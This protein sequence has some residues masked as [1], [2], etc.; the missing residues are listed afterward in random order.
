[1]STQNEFSLAPFLIDSGEN[2]RTIGRP[3]VNQFI[4]DQFINELI[5][6]LINELIN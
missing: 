2:K 5:N 1:M 3:K 4:M 6:S